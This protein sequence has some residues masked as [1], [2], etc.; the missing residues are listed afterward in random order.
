M[1]CSLVFVALDDLRMGKGNG[2]IGEEKDLG[3]KG[4]DKD[5]DKKKVQEQG[6]TKGEGGD[7]D[8]GLEVLN[9][10]KGYMVK[11]LMEELDKYSNTQNK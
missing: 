6:E 8:V 11:T 10:R 4:K 1:S 7:V 5:K 2:K 9:K 3:D